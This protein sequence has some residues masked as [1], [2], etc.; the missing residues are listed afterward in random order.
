MTPVN[1]PAVQEKENG[2]HTKK[3][4][5][6]VLTDI[7]EFL[8]YP[9]IL[10]TPKSRPKK[11]T[12][13]RVLTSAEAIA[14]MEAKEKQKKEEQ[15]AKELR[16]KER[17]EKKRQR[18]QEKVRKTE[19]KLKREAERRRKAEE[20]EA[21]KRRKAEQREAEKKRKAELRQKQASERG[22][23]GK[24][25]AVESG[26]QSA[27]ITSNECAI[28]LGVYED[29]VI[30]GTLEKEWI[31]CPNSDVCGKWMHCSCLST[32]EDGLYTCPLCQSSFS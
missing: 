5:E 6:R 13:P 14:M 19:E 23:Y 12:G 10:A 27:E 25:Q 17:E 11:S 1:T 21:E 30:D 22:R 32:D 28:C 9:V 26:L 18:E 16:K 8:N 31:Q 29:D 24:Q 7:T 2:A 20:R 15:E 4:C 3:S